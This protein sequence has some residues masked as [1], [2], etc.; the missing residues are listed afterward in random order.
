MPNCRYDVRDLHGQSDLRRRSDGAHIMHPEP[1]LVKER[2]QPMESHR[3]KQLLGRGGLLHR[4]VTHD[5]TSKISS[6]TGVRTSYPSC[7]TITVFSTPTAP[8]PGKTT[9]GS[10]EKTIPVSKG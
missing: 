9:L 10:K 3:R 8:S 1:F 7:V 2:N 4:D 5:H 6:S